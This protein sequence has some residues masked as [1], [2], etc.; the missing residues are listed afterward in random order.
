MCKELENLA[1]KIYIHINSGEAGTAGRRREHWFE[2]GEG[3]GGDQR[4]RRRERETI[5]QNNTFPMPRWQTSKFMTLCFIHVP[6]QMDP[7]VGEGRWCP[8]EQ[9]RAELNF[10]EDLTMV[11]SGSWLRVTLTSGFA[12]CPVL[13]VKVFLLFKQSASQRT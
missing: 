1:L 10:K 3:R 4:G 7:H 9:V 13:F 2:P 6:A 11:V 8:G 12:S 5:R